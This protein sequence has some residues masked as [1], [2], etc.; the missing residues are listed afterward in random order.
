MSDHNLVSCL[1]VTSGT[2][3]R[4][5]YFKEGVAGYCRQTYPNTELVV[6]IDAD[7]AD[8]RDATF[9]HIAGLGRDDIRVIEPGGGLS[10]GALRNVSLRNA[11]GDVVCHW[12]DDD[13]HHPERVARQ[14]EALVERRALSIC[15][16]EVMQFFP[17]ERTLYCTN[18]RAT[19]PKALPATMMCK[20]SAPIAYPEEGPTSRLGEDTAVIEQ[21]QR[22]GGFEV[23]G[24][25][26]HLYVY[27]SH[28]ENTYSQDHHRMLAATLSVSQGLMRRHEAWLREGLSVFD[29]GENEVA[30]QGSNGLAFTIA[31][32]GRVAEDG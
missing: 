27:V 14:L 21:L 20:V 30:V 22:E 7:Q 6:V 15:L 10:L 13:L 18:W 28:G 12:D 8:A 3:R 16:E 29:F 1:M 23:L 25:A 24:R 32:T 19:P 5:G 26:P 4:F 2:R 9:Q 31:G 17:A 11:R